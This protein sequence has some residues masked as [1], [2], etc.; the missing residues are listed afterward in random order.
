MEE[1][2][3]ICG[4]IIPEGLQVCPNCEKSSGSKQ[5]TRLTKWEISKGVKCVKYWQYSQEQ[6]AERLAILEDMLENGTLQFIPFKEGDTAYFETY[7]D[8]GST[9]LGVQPHKITGVRISALVKGNYVP[10]ELPLL[11]LGKHWFLSEAEAKEKLRE[12]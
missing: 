3:L 2:C 4:V 1:T 5:Y 10:I 8:N 11:H 12:D 7:T 9:N 6:I